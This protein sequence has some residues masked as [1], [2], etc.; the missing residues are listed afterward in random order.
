MKR[1]MPALLL[2]PLLLCLGLLECA[3]VSAAAPGHCQTFTATPVPNDP[4]AVRIVTPRGTTV[5]RRYAS[6]PPG[7]APT[8]VCSV[9]RGFF[10]FD[11]DTVSTVRDTV[12]LTQGATVRW[13]QYFPDFHTVTNGTDSGDLNAASE[14]N[15][16]LDGVTTRFDWTF[17]T[18]GQHDFFC[19]IHEPVMLGTIYIL[20]ASVDV[21]P[22]VIRKATFSRSPTPN[23]TRGEVRFA[24][25]LPR[26]TRVL[27]TVHD[28]TGRMLATL[29]DTSLPP[30]EHFVSWDGRA[31]DGRLAPAGRYFIRLAAGDVRESRAVS[32]IH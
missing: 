9:Y 16:I 19:F 20:P 26:T 8:A 29:R 14:F 15:A 17:N 13:I 28:V 11:H 21:K 24:I 22:G 6:L 10:D 27:L 25:A 31:R 3:P 4:N 32:L 5:A 23:P 7:Q 1:L 30:G 18:V 2:S 12:V